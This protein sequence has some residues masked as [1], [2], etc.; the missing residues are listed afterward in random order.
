MTGGRLKR[1]KDY[2]DNEPFFLTYG[3]GLSNIKIK[4]L[5]DF[6]KSHGKLATV[7]AVQPEGRF[8]MIDINDSETVT[9]FYE[10]PAG[11]GG[12]INGGFFVLS[13]KIF[14][15][16]NFRENIL[17]FFDFFQMAFPFTVSQCSQC[18]P[19]SQHY[20]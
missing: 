5:I 18:H 19:M 7:T 1:M 6:H 13:P 15:I 11:D 2:I 17:G 9:N 4:E 3:D 10:K 16:I 14:E 20:Y 12:Y 8:G